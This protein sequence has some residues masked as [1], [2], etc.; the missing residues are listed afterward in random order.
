MPK[1]Q[2]S[3]GLIATTFQ[4]AKKMGST[5]L[6]MLNHVAPNT[7]GKMTHSPDPEQVIQGQAKERTTAQPLDQQQVPNTASATQLGSSSSASYVDGKKHYDRPQQM[8]R[9]HLPKVSSQV[10]GR[11]YQRVNHITSFVSPE[12]NDKVSDYVFDRLNDVVAQFSS[13]SAVLK[14]VGAKDLAELAKDPA[15]SGRIT[16]ALANQNK[17]MAAAQGGISGISGLLGAAL[18]VPF[19]IALALRGIY[20]TGHAYGFELNTEDHLVVEFIFKQIDLSSVAE[21]QAVLAAIRA[22][23]QMLKNQDMQQLQQLLGSSNNSDYLHKYLLNAE[24]E[25]KWA[26][27][28][29]I[30]QTSFLANFTPLASLGVGASYS[31]KLVDEATSHAQRVFSQARLYLNQHPDVDIDALS[32]F[33]QSQQQENQA[34]GAQAKDTQALLEV[35]MTDEAGT[36]KK[37][38]LVKNETVESVPVEN[39]SL[40]N[41]PKPEVDPK[42]ETQVTIENVQQSG[43]TAPVEPVSTDSPATRTSASKDNS[44]NKNVTAPTTAESA[45]AVTSAAKPRQRTAK[46]TSAAVEQSAKSTTKSVKTPRSR[47]KTTAPDANKNEQIDTE[48]NKK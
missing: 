11:H 44:V 41:A 10:F 33:E 38:D 4:L 40:E 35:C 28:R 48:N 7:V 23:S 12:F 6:E 24:G 20:Q 17:V 22:F 27:M 18:D 9:E 15:R 39:N 2:R 34:E 3:T 16:Q 5:G 26:W 46:K 21:K 13:S 14:E 19:S 29:H 47:S 45:T 36:E 25:M 31:Y 8:L 37:A 42:L 30:P 43:S 1:S 32:A